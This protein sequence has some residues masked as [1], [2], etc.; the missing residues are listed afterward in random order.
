[1][2]HSRPKVTQWFAREKNRPLFSFLTCEANE[3]VRPIHAKAMPVVLSEEAEFEAWLS[4]PLEE[5]LEGGIMG[6]A[7]WGIS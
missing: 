1:M 5:A 6:M 2:D 3:L 7:E 4:A